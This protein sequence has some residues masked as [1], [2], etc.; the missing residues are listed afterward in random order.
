MMFDIDARF[1][2]R[3][4][5]GLLGLRSAHGVAGSAV[6]SDGKG[7]SHRDTVLAVGGRPIRGTTIVQLIDALAAEFEC[8]LQ[9]GPS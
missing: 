3:M 5:S 2:A 4:V 7:D 6:R 9:E 1:V 8:H